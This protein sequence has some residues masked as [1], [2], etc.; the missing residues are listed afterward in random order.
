MP[1]V[2]ALLHTLA[3]RTVGGREH[4]VCADV[5]VCAARD[6]AGHEGVDGGGAPGAAADAQRPLR[7]VAADAAGRLGRRRPPGRVLLGGQQVALMKTL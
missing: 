4:T 5:T 1:H 3:Y 6:T 2:C 7:Y